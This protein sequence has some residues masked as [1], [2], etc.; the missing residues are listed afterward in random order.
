[1]KT[2]K[3]VLRVYTTCKWIKIVFFLLSVILGS[4][5]K[6]FS[7]RTVYALSPIACNYQNIPEQD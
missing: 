2:N 7:G 5:L 3:R 4:P 6:T 1:M